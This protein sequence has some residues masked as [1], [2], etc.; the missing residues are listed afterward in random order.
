[1]TEIYGGVLEYVGEV[2]LTDQNDNRYRAHRYRWKHPD[3]REFEYN[4]DA[5][6]ARFGNFSHEK[7]AKVAIKNYLK[8]ACDD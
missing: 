6:L 5:G 3:G 7:L 2:G 8:E 4:V 1:M